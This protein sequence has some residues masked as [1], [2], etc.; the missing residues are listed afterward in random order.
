MN[1]VRLR[2]VFDA[3]GP[4]DLWTYGSRRKGPV[5]SQGPFVAYHHKRTDLCA[6]D[7]KAAGCL[8]HWLP[9]ASQQKDCTGDNRAVLGWW[10]I[11]SLLECCG[12]AELCWQRPW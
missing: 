12:R 11:V 4:V 2:D 1:Y 5:L 8:L 7:L 10:K 6:G 3:C 9:S